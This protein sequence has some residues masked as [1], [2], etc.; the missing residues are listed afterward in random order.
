MKQD[1]HARK[2]IEALLAMVRNGDEDAFS[3]L[4]DRFSPML[5]AL[6]SQFS[7]GIA[8]EAEQAQEA[9]IAL[10]RAALTYASA[11][12]AVTFGLYARICVRNALIS[13]LRAHH[14]AADACS[15]DELGAGFWRD[16]NSPL[17]ALITAEAAADIYR[18]A[19]TVL[20]SFERR[21]FELYM[22]E[23]S[24]ERMARELGKSEKSVRNAIQRVRA[25]LRGSAS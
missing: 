6:L 13:F 17:D 23:Q 3:A 24:V 1:E 4:C 10:Y 19:K 5:D 7:C 8:Y 22:E 16:D 21:V 11:D 12:G 20:S 15:L 9:R 18:R 14:K 25:K 2:E